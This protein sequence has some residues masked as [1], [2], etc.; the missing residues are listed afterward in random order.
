VKLTIAWKA[1]GLDPAHATLYA[2]PIAG[3]Q[4]ERLWRPGEPIPV[5][6]KQGWFLVLDA[7]ARAIPGSPPVADP[8]RKK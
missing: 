7:V 2:P 6:P 8:V 5:A 4:T 3:M 1:L